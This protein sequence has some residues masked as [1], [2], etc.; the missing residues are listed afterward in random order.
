MVCL[1]V[2]NMLSNFVYNLVNILILESTEQ[3]NSTKFGVQEE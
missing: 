1:V 2:Y 3:W